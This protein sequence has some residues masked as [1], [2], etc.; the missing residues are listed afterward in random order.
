MYYWDLWF[1][2][3]HTYNV[4]A[5]ACACVYAHALKKIIIRFSFHL[6]L[7][8]YLFYSFFFYFIRCF[9]LIDVC[10]GLRFPPISNYAHQSSLRRYLLQ[11]HTKL[12]Y[13]KETKEKR[14]CKYK[15]QDIF[16]DKYFLKLCSRS[17]KQALKNIQFFYI[18]WFARM[19]YSYS[20]LLKRNK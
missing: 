3:I 5:C 16:R 4:C 20:P 7:L 11:K 15:N 9:G 17:W 8:M 19:F 1:L 6:Y 14:D 10:N 2:T 12:L 18:L 13:F